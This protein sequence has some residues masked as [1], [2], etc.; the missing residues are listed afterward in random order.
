MDIERSGCRAVY[1]APGDVDIA[2]EVYGYRS[3]GSLITMHT[4]VRYYDGPEKLW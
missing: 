3:A 2:D 1:A 4:Y